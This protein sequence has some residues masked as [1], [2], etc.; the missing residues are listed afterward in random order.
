[1]QTLV[2][3]TARS[4]RTQATVLGGSLATLWGV[5]AG[6][7]VVGGGLLGFGIHP[8]T[9]QGLWGIAAAPFLHASLEHLV[10][11]SVPLVVLGWLV[12][13]RDRRHFWP[14]TIIAALGSGL[15]AWTI[16]APGTVHVGASGVIFGY[17]GFLLLAGWFARS[18]GAILLSVLVTVLWGGLV[19]G[20]LP[21]QVGISWEAHLGGFLGGVLAARWLAPRGR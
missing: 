3:S 21:G 2:R 12:M 10:A 11:N 16:G 4:V 15:T 13:L 5:F 8:R 1:M 9:V 7:V 20:V 17:L 14:V 18:A 19:F 6:N